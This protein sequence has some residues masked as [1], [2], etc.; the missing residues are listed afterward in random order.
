MQPF[1]SSRRPCPS[2]LLFFTF[3]FLSTTS[4]PLTLSGC[5]DRMGQG[6]NA[7]PSTLAAATSS[8]GSGDEKND[9]QGLRKKKQEFFAY[10]SRLEQFQWATMEDTGNVTSRYNEKLVSPA[11]HRYAQHLRK[12]CQV[13]DWQS[14]LAQDVERYPGINEFVYEVISGSQCPVRKTVKV[15]GYARR[16]RN[17]VRLILQ[18]R[19]EFHL[20]GKANSTAKELLALSNVRVFSESTKVTFFVLSDNTVSRTDMEIESTVEHADG[21]IVLASS[22]AAMLP[23][24]R[25]WR[26]V[27]VDS[28]RKYSFLRP[29]LDPPEQFKLEIV[30]EAEVDDQ[31]NTHVKSHF[32]SWN[33]MPLTQDEISQFRLGLH[34]VMSKAER[35]NP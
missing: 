9:A 6:G 32:A 2:P 14:R 25:S 13:M 27:Q 31:G 35:L 20:L 24:P 22:T 5:V 10:M 30:G 21:H 1:P 23:D 12:R 4:L 17:G 19:E 33:E 28:T 18:L 26:L 3:L 11:F 15:E 34:Q 8:G 16:H 29:N 7:S